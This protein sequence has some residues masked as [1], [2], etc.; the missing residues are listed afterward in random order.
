MQEST[1]AGWN[2]KQSYIIIL[3]YIIYKIA[4]FTLAVRLCSYK[5][6]SHQKT[7]QQILIVKKYLHKIQWVRMTTGVKGF[8]FIVLFTN[9]IPDIFPVC[10]SMWCS[11]WRWKKNGIV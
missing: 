11:Q 10:S 8:I 4:N 3:Y 2:K 5:S 9:H 6:S 1:D 7:Y